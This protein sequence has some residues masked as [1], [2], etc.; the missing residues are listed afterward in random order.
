MGRIVRVDHVN[1]YKPPKDEDEIEQDKRKR[2]FK[3]RDR[4]DD[5]PRN[6]DFKRRDDDSN[7]HDFKRPADRR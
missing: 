4:D 3:R 1:D 7:R 5:G 6:R 2:D